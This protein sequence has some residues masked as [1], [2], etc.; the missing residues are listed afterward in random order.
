ME[1]LNENQMQEILDTLYGKALDGIPLVSKSIDEL[2]YDYLSKNH[3]NA[4]SA[5]KSLIN[6]QTLKCGT[7]GFLTG[8]GGLITLPVAIPANV[9]SVLYVQMRMIATIAQMGGFD[10]HADQVQS[11]V[12]VCLTGSAA[13]DIMKKSGI[14]VGERVALNA[15]KSIPGKTLTQINQKVGMRLFTKFGEKGVVNLGK[16][17]PIVGGVIG[18]GVDIASTRIIGGNAY[19]MFIDKLF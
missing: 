7:S 19:R 4:S 3:H 11:L 14:K 2:A 1:L 9:S 18:G 5:A 17:I 15:I 10:T 16:T 6:Y 8:L 13:A 12:Y